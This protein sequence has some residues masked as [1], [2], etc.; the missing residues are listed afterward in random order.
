M[1]IK[2]VVKLDSDQVKNRIPEI[3][4]AIQ[5]AIE[6]ALHQFKDGDNRHSQTITYEIEMHEEY[7]RND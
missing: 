7:L 4:D 1:Q 5:F 3:V 6:G 2:A